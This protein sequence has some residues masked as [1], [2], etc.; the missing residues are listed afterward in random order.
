MFAVVHGEGR[1][2]ISL[3]TKALVC[4]QSKRMHNKKV[5]IQLCKLIFKLER[6]GCASTDVLQKEHVL[7]RKKTWHHLTE[8]GSQAL[9]FPLRHLRILH[10]SAVSQAAGSGAV[11]VWASVQCTHPSE[12]QLEVES[13]QGRAMGK[14]VREG[15]TILDLFQHQCTNQCLTR[16]RVRGFFFYSCVAICTVSK[17]SHEPL[18]GF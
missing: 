11:L 8:A 3:L 13:L 9:W 2:T 10:V 7:R 15:S 5:N 17:T 6:N 12:S 4:Y 14:Q 1:S 18:N 16:S